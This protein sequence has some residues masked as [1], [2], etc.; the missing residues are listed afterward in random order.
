MA[1]FTRRMAHLVVGAI[2]CVAGGCSVLPM[3]VGVY[4]VETGEP[5]PDAWVGIESSGINI[6]LGSCGGEIG[7]GSQSATTR[8]DG[9]AR[10]TWPAT[11]RSSINVVSPN[12]GSTA[13]HHEWAQALIDGEPKRFSKPGAA[14]PPALPERLPDLVFLL[15]Q[16]KAGKVAPSEPAP[17]GR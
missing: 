12:E 5:I 8:A 17:A 3:T 13:Y 7:G 2:A 16:N 14:R 9:I 4:D 6:P 1:L 15:W 10:L 11:Q